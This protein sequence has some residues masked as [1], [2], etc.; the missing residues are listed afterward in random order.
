MT[1]EGMSK[2][3][4][5]RLKSDFMTVAKSC[6]DYFKQQGTP[7]NFE[8]Y[9]KTIV[10]YLSCETFNISR[11]EFL[12]RDINLWMIYMGD[13]AAFVENSMMSLQNK[14]DYFNAFPKVIETV[15]KIRKFK[16]DY[17]KIKLLYK[18]LIIQE[19]MFKMM[20]IQ[21]RNLYNKSCETYVYRSY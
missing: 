17:I 11:L 20:S 16:D 5:T 19:R 1:N 9:T 2:T 15:K 4:I 13:T 12:I 7:L 6:K 18:N 3:K 10:D 14:I 21:C 8:G